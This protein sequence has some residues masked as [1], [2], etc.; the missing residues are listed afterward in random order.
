MQD[1]SIG[2]RPSRPLLR[3]A[4]VPP[5]KAGALLDLYVDIF[6]DREP[7]TRHLGSSRAR[8]RGLARSLYLDPEMPS[9]G[10][11]QWWEAR[12]RDAAGPRIGLLV[13]ED[14]VA[15][16]MTDP[17]PGM[18]PEE[19]KAFPSMMALFE[20][21]RQPLADRTLREGECFRVAA[22]GV[23]AGHEG[24][25]VAARLL[26]AALERARDMGFRHA[27]AE[28]TGPASRRCHERCG[29]RSLLAVEYASFEYE[30]QRPFA[31]LPGICHLMWADLA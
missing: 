21:I 16:A 22:V 12:D 14:L 11:R 2:G 9:Y 28:C 23:V 7:L 19:R 18:T 17:P 30:G 6:H 4:R 3:I 13:G 24:R 10:R 8:M 20:A 15:D 29:F 27:M 31:D 25:G 5:E 26:E 1:A